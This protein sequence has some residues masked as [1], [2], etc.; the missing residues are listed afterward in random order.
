MGLA[1][2]GPKFQVTIPKSAREAVGLQVGDLVEATV[3][4]D[5]ILLR[6]KLV[7]DKRLDI[8]KRLEAAEADVKA[9]RVLGPFKS[10]R[11]ALR[12]VKRRAHARPAH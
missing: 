9:G 3:A 6:P 8:K 1:K 11:A 12:A 4:R 7:L 2:I 5:G 10:A